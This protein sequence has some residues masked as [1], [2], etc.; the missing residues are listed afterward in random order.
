ME[1]LSG[2]AS[3][4]KT[5]IRTIQ[6]VRKNLNTEEKVYH[7]A[8][9]ALYAAKMVEELSTHCYWITHVPETIKEAKTILKSDVEWIPCSDARYKYAA[10]DS[11]Y[12]GIDQKW[13]LFHSEERHKAS[14]KRDIEKIEEK[15]A[16][17]QTALNKSLVNGFACENDARL[18]VERWMSKH[19]RYILSDIEIKCDN[20]KKSGKVGRPKKGEVLEKWYY[21][22]CKLALNQEVIQKEQAMMGRFILASNDTN[23]DPNTCLE[24]YKEQNAVERGFRFIKGNSF[25]ASEVYLENSN[26]VAALS[27]I[28]VLCLLVYSFTE[29][30]V[31][32]TLKIEK[33]KI[34]DQKGKP[35]QRPSAKWLFFMFRRVRQIK[36][37]DNSRIIVRILNLTDELR[38]IVR[39]I[40]PHV[41]KYYA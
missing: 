10:F 14:I 28:M 23:V 20:K 39:L 3:D 25:H 40:G 15:L 38:D 41:E 2:N 26:R 11:R 35:T 13:F 37:I 27:M 6:E 29:W 32:E 7:M 21:V 19:K 33:K 16:T 22:S 4:K 5:L 24:Y 17:S 18:A 12:G 9:S 31:R 34:R 36:E 8:D 30:V 1:P